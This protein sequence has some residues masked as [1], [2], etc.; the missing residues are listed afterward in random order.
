LVFCELA[1]DGG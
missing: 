1:D